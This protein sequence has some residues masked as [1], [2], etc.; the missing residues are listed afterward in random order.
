[1]KVAVVIPIY[2]QNMTEAE[3]K[4]LTQAKKVLN[5]YDFVLFG[6]DGLSLENY[7]KVTADFEWIGF[8][9]KY[10][11]SVDGYSELLLS[12]NFYK[13]F[14][15]YDYI[16]IYQLDAWVFEDALETWCN[17]KYDY[18]GAPWL[19]KPPLTKGRPRM[20]LTPYFVNKVG[21]GGFSLR[22]T[23][24][25]YRN[26]LIFRPLLKY[27]IKNEDMFWGLFLYYLN[28][29]FTRPK[30]IEAL[31]F[32][33]EMEPRKAFEITS[34]NLPFGVHAWEKYDPE[35]WKEWIK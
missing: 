33:F 30:A 12:P 34:H 25:H 10:F 4:S 32:A 11:S 23:K 18:I 13:K 7:M 21:N 6:P 16:L 3:E 5:R 17:K 9:N 24:S 2:K 27:F 26:C 15:D 35:F 31:N 14:F 22:K 28:P 29:F 20:D 19:S 1:M 8:E